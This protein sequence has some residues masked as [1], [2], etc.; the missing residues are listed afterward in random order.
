[1]KSGEPVEQCHPTIIGLEARSVRVP[2]P[3]PHQ[4]ASGTITDSPLVLID[5]VTDEGTRGHAIVFTYTATAL[6]PTAQLVRGMEP[7]IKGAPLAPRAI[8]SRLSKRFRLLGTQGLVGMAMAGIDMAAWDALARYQRLPLVRLLGGEPCPVPVYGGI[9]YDG[10]EGVARAAER[11]AELGVGGVKAK[12]GYPTVDEDLAVIRAMRDAAGPGMAIMVD[13]NQS[14]SEAEAM[15]RLP[16]LDEEELAWVEEP[17]L[18]HDYRG[19][20]RLAERFQTPIQCGENWWG[21]TDLQHAID[22][23]TRGLVMADAMK[24]GGVTGWLR[25]ASL[26]E[27]HGLRVSSHLWTELSARLLCCTPTGHW[28]EYIDWWNPV[29]QAPLEIRDGHVLPDDLVGSGISWDEDAIRRLVH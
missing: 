11:W 26:A 14:L 17:L 27:A 19:H 3:H 2:M 9:G 22:A 12:I 25:A 20:A 4:T 7:L 15:H 18:A 10:V 23:G 8:E 29:L 28:L 21:A 6:E 13:Y 1:M 24:I 16:R 5:L